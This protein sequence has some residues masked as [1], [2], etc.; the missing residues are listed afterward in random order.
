MSKVKINPKYPVNPGMTDEKL[1]IHTLE[2]DMLDDVSRFPTKEQLQNYPRSAGS[3]FYSIFNNNDWED[4]ATVYRA[5]RDQRYQIMDQHYN[6]AIIRRLPFQFF[7][8]NSMGFR[9]INYDPT[10]GFLRDG[11]YFDESK[12]KNTS[13]MFPSME[14][15]SNNFPLLYPGGEGP[16]KYAWVNSDMEYKEV[17][18]KI[19]P[20]LKMRDAW[21]SCLW[22]VYQMEPH[23]DS[24]N[25]QTPG[26]Y[27]YNME[28]SYPGSTR[29]T[30][31]FDGEEGVDKLYCYVDNFK[32]IFDLKVKKS[33]AMSI[34][35]G[36][37]E[38]PLDQS[39][40]DIGEPTINQINNQL[41]DRTAYS[42]SIVLDYPSYYDDPSMINYI[43]SITNEP[44]GELNLAGLSCADIFGE[45]EL[46]WLPGVRYIAELA[47][48]QGNV[49]ECIFVLEYDNN[50]YRE[51]AWDPINEEWSVSFFNRFFNPIIGAMTA[52]R[53]DAKWLHDLLFSMKPFSWASHHMPAMWIFDG[54]KTEAEKTVVDF[55]T[56][57]S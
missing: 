34:G 25:A 11:F 18:Y 39:G 51:Y 36:L 20:S 16:I 28:Q 46:H 53:K 35:L 30:T 21:A 42:E 22:S 48:I 43:C 12:I 31:S 4:L 19:L 23:F 55:S 2:W 7:D 50:S 15:G 5:Q 52:E 3:P 6:N 32:K 44:T 13:I 17:A 38:V 40:N 47:N 45:A 8:S 56:F 37:D 9:S 14:D 24:P 49:G 1:R 54:I 41:I 26:D 33:N 57:N 27:V 29:T 10:L